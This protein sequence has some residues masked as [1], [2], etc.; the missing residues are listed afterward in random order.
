MKNI[1]IRRKKQIFT[2]YIIKSN[3]KMFVQYY[4]KSGFREMLYKN[5]FDEQGNDF[6]GTSN[7]EISLTIIILLFNYNSLLLIAK[8]H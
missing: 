7:R 2:E 1:R 3:K 8:Y 4:Q 6:K 5:Q